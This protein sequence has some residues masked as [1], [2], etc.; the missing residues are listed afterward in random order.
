MLTQPANRR[1]STWIS[2]PH[3]LFR[4]AVVLPGLLVGAVGWRTIDADRRGAM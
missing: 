2:H 3:V 4:L 1:G